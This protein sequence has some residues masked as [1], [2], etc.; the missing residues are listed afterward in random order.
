MTLTLDFAA[1]F[2]RRAAQSGG[3]RFTPQHLAQLIAFAAELQHVQPA[4][5][6]AGTVLRQ[7][8]SKATDLSPQ[9]VRLFALP[10]PPP[11]PL[12]ACVRVSVLALEQTN[13]NRSRTPAL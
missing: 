7:L 5:A 4:A 13:G 3:Q 9:G 8:E 10:P 12:C 2:A 11:S 1:A 6:L